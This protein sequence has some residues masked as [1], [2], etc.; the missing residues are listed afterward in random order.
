VK[1]SF[2]SND[3]LA[4]SPVEVI[5]LESNDFAGA[6][7]K[8]GQQKKNGVVAAAYR[9]SAVAGCKNTSD[10]VRREVLRYGGQTPVRDRKDTTGQVFF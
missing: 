10:L 7:T 1:Q 2:A 3:N 6:K 4:D 9:R 5:E 8:T